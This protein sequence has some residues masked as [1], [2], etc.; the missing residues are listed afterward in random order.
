LRVVRHVNERVR[1]CDVPKDAAVYN[2]ADFV[3]MMGAAL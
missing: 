2:F 1:H 3:F